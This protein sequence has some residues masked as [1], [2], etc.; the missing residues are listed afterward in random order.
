MTPAQ[1]AT[2]M[3]ASFQPLTEVGNPR[4]TD[5][6]DVP[7]CDWLDDACGMIA[8]AA[9][10]QTKDMPAVICDDEV[11]YE[12]QGNTVLFSMPRMTIRVPGVAN[13]AP[14]RDADLLKGWALD[15][16]F[17][18]VSAAQRGAK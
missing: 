2:A 3:A 13:G 16:W 6:G 8:Y 9:Q 15:E 1:K 5:P 7:A 12:V 4:G 14:I 17:L 10:S 11:N 18:A